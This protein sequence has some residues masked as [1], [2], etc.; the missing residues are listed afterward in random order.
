MWCFLLR[1]SH[2]C[3][4]LEVG[5]G[6]GYVVCSIALALQQLSSQLT[7]QAQDAAAAAA[8]AAHTQPAFR[9]LAPCQ[10]FATDINPAALHATAQTLAAHEVRQ[11]ASSSKALRSGAVGCACAYVR[12][13]APCA[14]KPDS[15]WLLCCNPCQPH[16][17]SRSPCWLLSV[18]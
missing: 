3:S 5:C 17:R 2:C 7:R 13:D 14:Q 1:P 15:C 12:T 18:H 8:Q 9:A 11:P 4:C 16:L 10:F 6:S